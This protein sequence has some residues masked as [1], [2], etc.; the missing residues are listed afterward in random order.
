MTPFDEE[1]P[2]AAEPETAEAAVPADL[3]GG[4]APP[5]AGP[6]EEEAIA[7][8]AAAVVAEREA[9]AMEDRVPPGSVIERTPTGWAVRIV[10]GG[11]PRLFG[12]GAT[13]TAALRQAGV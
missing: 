3:S 10:Y 13:L 5:A 4:D 1:A 2:V 9:Q 8:R 7:A 11:A 6:N 12:E